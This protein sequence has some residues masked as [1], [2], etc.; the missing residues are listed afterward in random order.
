M[1][2]SESIAALAAALSAAQGQFKA[3]QK[4]RTNTFLKN[5]YATLDDI[6]AVVRE[7]LHKNGL[8]FIQPLTGTGDG[9]EIETILIHESGEWLSCK[10]AI[11]NWAAKGVNELQKF[12]GALTYMRRYM[13]SS[14]LG[15]SSDEDA[16]GNG[17][18][19]SG[20]KK[21]VK[22]A[23]EK[24]EPKAKAVSGGAKESTPAKKKSDPLPPEQWASIK[25]PA[26][27]VDLWGGEMWRLIGYKAK[28]H[29]LNVLTNFNPQ[30]VGEAWGHL[31]EHQK[32][33]LLEPP[34]E[35]L[36]F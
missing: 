26:E 14:M 6:I 35:E 3:A 11:P 23:A 29:A 5:K 10:S 16:D 24:V 19:S 27:Y 20:K 28:Q 7:P 9:F 1:E 34:A 2:R 12:G 8:S 30:N 18:R 25:P 15:V 32:S 36:K 21:A 17:A 4:S 33:K 31:L 22:K 13:L